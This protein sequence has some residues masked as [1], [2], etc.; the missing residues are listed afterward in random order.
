MQDMETGLT[1]KQKQILDWIEGYLNTHQTMPSRREIATGLGL[2]SP[3]TIQ[4]HIE[5]LEKKGY[6]KRGEGRESRALQWTARSKKLF[7]IQ[8][9]SKK[10]SGTPDDAPPPFSAINSIKMKPDENWDAIPLIGTIAAGYP[11]EVFTDP[12]EKRIPLDLFVSEKSALRKKGDLF[13]LSVRG[14]SMIDD[15]IFPNDWVILKRASSARPGETVAALLN[16]EAT[17]KRFQKSKSGFE[18]HPANPRYPIIPV[19]EEDRFEIQGILIGLIR[20][21]SGTSAG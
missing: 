14:D 2:S 7:S 11:I 16:G 6:L 8:S 15:G 13:M 21:Y 12:I 4:Q 3:A 19:T 17:L 9:S 20:N 5:A 10:D 1:P 18:L